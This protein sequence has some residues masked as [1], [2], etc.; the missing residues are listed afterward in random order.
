MKN[1]N[2]AL[3]L[4]TL[5]H[6]AEQQHNWLKDHFGNQTAFYLTSLFQQHSYKHGYT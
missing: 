4:A 2:V 6:Q 3:S 1:P 5:D